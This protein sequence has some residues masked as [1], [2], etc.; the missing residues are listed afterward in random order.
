M[1]LIGTVKGTR[2]F[3]DNIYGGT[4]LQIIACKYVPSTKPRKEESADAKNPQAEPKKMQQSP[5]RQLTRRER[6]AKA[7]QA[8]AEE[9]KRRQEE[10]QATLAEAS[11][12]RELNGALRLLDRG[13]K[14]EARKRL[15]AIVEKYPDTPTAERAKRQLDKMEK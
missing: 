1:D 7:R 13:F 6:Q 9:E 5:P 4:M 2:P 14:D 12:K 15:K 11:I 8:A 10:Y 3:A